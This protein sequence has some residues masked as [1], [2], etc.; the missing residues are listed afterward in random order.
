[1]PRFRNETTRQ[2]YLE[3]DSLLGKIANAHTLSHRLGLPERTVRAHLSRMTKRGIVRRDG[4]VPTLF[5]I[6]V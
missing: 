2:I 4:D 6:A 3:L 5:E 1:M